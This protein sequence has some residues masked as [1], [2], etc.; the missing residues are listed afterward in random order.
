MTGIGWI[1]QALHS[2]V[3]AVSMWAAEA[4]GAADAGEATGASQAAVVE[5][6]VTLRVPR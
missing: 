4:P 1:L 3:L 6:S 2:I 5:S